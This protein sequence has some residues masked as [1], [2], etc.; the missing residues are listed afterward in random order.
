MHA[1]TTREFGRVH[2]P[3]TCADSSTYRH[4]VGGSCSAFDQAACEL[5]GWEVIDGATARDACCACAAALPTTCADHPYHIVQGGAP[6]TCAQLV[7]S[8][9]AL[10]LTCTAE[11]DSFSWRQWALLPDDAL[12]VA[13]V[14]AH[15]CGIC[16]GSA[17]RAPP[18]PS[19]CPSGHRNSALRGEAEAYECM[20]AEGSFEVHWKVGAHATRFALVD[21]TT[22]DALALGFST[23]GEMIGAQAVIGWFDGSGAASVSPYALNGKSESQVVPTAAFAIRDVAGSASDGKTTIKFVIDHATRPAA[24]RPNGTST[25]LWARLGVEPGA[26]DSSGAPGAGAANATANA[27]ESCTD[28][29]V[30]LQQVLGRA[31]ITCAL[32]AANNRC[33]S[34]C[35]SALGMCC[36]SCSAP[37]SAAATADR[38]LALT[39][40]RLATPTRLLSH[41]SRRGA[42]VLNLEASAPPPQPPPAS[43]V[44]KA[45]NSQALSASSG[46]TAALV[47]GIAGGVAALML[48]LLFGFIVYARCKSISRLTAAKAVRAVEAELTSQTAESDAKI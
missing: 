7:A 12:T 18:P 36:V 41:G 26:D 24:L 14:C 45:D 20:H 39:L 22:T 15:S 25:I 13:A 21:R 34:N 42:F 33:T 29:D 6:A 48:L 38:R 47:G 10:G 43:P 5:Y 35:A 27:T 4:P 44:D 31:S 3:P 8:L 32:V 46:N 9:P 2:T 30:R 40:R 1:F 23:T 28:D 17:L 16:T 37:C 19:P 11:W